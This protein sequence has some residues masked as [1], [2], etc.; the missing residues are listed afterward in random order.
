MWTIILVIFITQYELEKKKILICPQSFKQKSE[1]NLMKNLISLKMS[2]CS[3]MRYILFPLIKMMNKRCW[4]GRYKN[5]NK[6]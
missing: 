3:K 2:P 1:K 6:W 4:R 5:K